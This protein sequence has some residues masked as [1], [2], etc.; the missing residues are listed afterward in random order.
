MAEKKT[1]HTGV[2][3]A[4][5]LSGAFLSGKEERP[6]TGP[7]SCSSVDRVPGAMAGISMITI[8][9]LLD[10]N[11]DSTQLLLQ[12]TRTYH[13][14]HI[15]MPGICV[16]TCSLYAYSAWS[17]RAARSK[18]WLSLLIAGVTTIT[19]VPFTWL[20]MNRTNNELFA[21]E[22]SARSGGASAGPKRPTVQELLTRW[23]WL[24]IARSL[25]P[26]VGSILGF[27][28]L[29]ESVGP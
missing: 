25:F 6:T 11:T 24:H 16:S 1:P 15:I 21:L 8:P 19:M 28:A 26:L 14:G 4:A 5:V 12:W 2:R 18:Q 27:R 17:R 22:A 20:V 9:V 10:T 7:Q 13:Y 3:S 23:A 29:W